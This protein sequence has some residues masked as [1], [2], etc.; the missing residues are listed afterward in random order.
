M[1]RPRLAVATAKEER[2]K[3]KVGCSW[4]YAVVP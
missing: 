3:W 4:V 2:N 1:V